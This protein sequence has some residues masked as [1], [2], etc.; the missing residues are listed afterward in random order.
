ME[1]GGRCVSGEGVCPL[2]VAGLVVLPDL[3]VLVGVVKYWSSTQTKLDVRLGRWYQKLASSKV[4]LLSLS[5]SGRKT[6]SAVLNW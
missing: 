4:Q 6:N 5:G 3:V 1:G 2:G